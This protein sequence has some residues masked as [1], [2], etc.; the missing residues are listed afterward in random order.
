MIQ[1]QIVCQA[2]HWERAPRKTGLL[3]TVNRARL[4]RRQHRV[5]LSV[6]ITVHLPARS[7]PIQVVHQ[8]C[9]NPQQ[10]LLRLRS[11]KQHPRLSR[12]RG[13]TVRD[14]SLSISPVSGESRK[15]A[16]IAGGASVMTRSKRARQVMFLACKEKFTC[17]FMN[18]CHQRG[19]ERSM[20]WCNNTKQYQT[21]LKYRY[22]PT[23]S[24]K[25]DM[26]YQSPVTYWPPQVS[27][28]RRRGPAQDSL[29]CTLLTHTAEFHHWKSLS[30][31][32][33]A[34]FSTKDL[35]PPSLGLPSRS[36]LLNLVILKFRI[37]KLRNSQ[38]LV[39]FR[40][41]YFRNL[42]R[43]LRAKSSS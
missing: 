5:H 2:R 17:S 43:R 19:R 33:L 39:V 31:A 20:N 10:H 38:N 18:S 23:A 3:N 8:N 14:Q 6:A 15:S 32:G 29:E 21:I 9:R 22:Q 27:K 1:V 41:L 12:S 36:I 16:A 7:L 26:Y 37:S 42:K 28:F 11:L 34:I 30:K 4:S 24:V 35:R 40:S 13:P 25:P